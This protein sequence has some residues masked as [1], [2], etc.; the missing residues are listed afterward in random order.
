MAVVVG[1]LSMAAYCFAGLLMMFGH[2]FGLLV[3]NFVLFGL[4]WLGTQGAQGKVPGMASDPSDAASDNPIPRIGGILLIVMA[5]PLFWYSAYQ[6]IQGPRDLPEA[7][8]STTQ[9]E[10]DDPPATPPLDDQVPA[11]AAASVNPFDLS[12]IP[13]PVFKDE[14]VA[15]KSSSGA[16]YFDIICEPNGKLMYGG[17][18]MQMRLRLPVQNASPQ[19][20]ACVLLS[21]SGSNP[22]VGMWLDE[23]DYETEVQPFLAAG[24]AVLE[25]STDGGLRDLQNPSNLDL[26]K[27]YIA[28]TTAQA[29]LV[30]ARN[31]LEFVLTRVPEVD[32]QR[33]YMTGHGSAGTLAI[34]FAEHEPRIKACLAFA[35]LTDVNTYLAEKGLFKSKAARQVFPG[36]EEFSTRVS[37]VN[38]LSRLGCP[39]FLFQAHDDTVEPVVNAMKFVEQAKSLGKNVTY[40]EEETGDHY[41]SMVDEGLYAALEWLR[42][43][44]GEKLTLPERPPMPTVDLNLAAASG[45]LSRPPKVGER[46]VIFRYTDLPSTGIPMDRLRSIAASTARL[47]PAVIYID[48]AGKRV[49]MGYRGGSLATGSLS[50]LLTKAGFELTQG[51]VLTRWTAQ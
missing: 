1:Y 2:Q 50:S 34:L 35:P 17:A 31:A 41:A 30:N 47:N 44:R 49:V 12:S 3:F 36:A 7:G 27:G 11:V 14:R 22:L 15:R 23:P 16:E 45:T 20:L 8:G 25:Y 5:S 42:D 19:S 46:V 40:Q 33:I 39:V 38:H 43:K 29:G 9:A 51:S 13:L 4:T 48:E 32:P 21:P 37:P 18:E 10:T 6:R 26:Q 28:F 24:L